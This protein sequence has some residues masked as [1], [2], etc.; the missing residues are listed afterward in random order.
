MGLRPVLRLCWSRE[1]GCQESRGLTFWPSAWLDGYGGRIGAQKGADVASTTRPRGRH[2]HGGPDVAKRICSIDECGEKHW[3]RSWCRKHYKRW[4]RAGDPLGSSMDPRW[5]LH[6]ERLTWLAGVIRYKGNECQIWPGP[7]TK[8]GYPR[9]IMVKKVRWVIS[10]YVL[11]WTARPRLR[12]NAASVHLCR[13][14]ACLTP[15]H[16]KW[17]GGH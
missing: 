3:C 14:R 6:V 12:S 17:S 7:L 2:L 4:V 11:T 15:T 1:E 13:N 10:H 9:P 8:D 5:V 16:L